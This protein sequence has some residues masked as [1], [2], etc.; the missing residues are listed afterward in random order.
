MAK[1]ENQ[2]IL[3]AVIVLSLFAAVIALIFSAGNVFNVGNASGIFLKAEFEPSVITD[4]QTATLFIRIENQKDEI[5]QP[6]VKIRTEESID[7]NYI[8]IA[9]KE[10]WLYPMNFKGEVQIRKIN[11]TAFSP[12]SESK[13]DIFVEVMD[14]NLTVAT[15]RVSLT[16][17][18]KG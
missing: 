1:V 5:S 17:Q 8:R 16:V 9:E 15:E 4:N 13:F 12:A 6:L 14:K 3:L 7:E 18:R 11:V 10:W 2:K